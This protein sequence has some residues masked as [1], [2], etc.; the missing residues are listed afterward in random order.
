VGL[1]VCDSADA[2]ATATTTVNV[3]NVA[4]TAVAEADQTVFRGAPVSVSGTWTDPAGA[5]DNAYTWAWDLDGDG[6][7]DVSGQSPFGS[8]NAQTTSF[9][10]LGTYTLTFRVTDKD[11]ASHSD[12][13]TITV[14]NR[15]PDC[16]AAAPS[17]SLIWPPNHQMVGVSVQGVT[18]ADNDPLTLTISSIHQDEPVNAIGDGNTGVDGTGVGSSEAMVR[19]ERSG[20]K[21]NFGNGRVYHIG[22]TADDGQGGSCSGVV[23]V[24]VPHDQ[25]GK[26]QPVDDGPLYDSTK[27]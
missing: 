3:L 11:G 22:Y 8:T 13:V 2:C 16:S 9:A 21:Q 25:G 14:V 19:A 12:T 17:T 23:R 20:T 1:R 27:P 4:P 15:P 10:A 26:A 7:F 18:D 6:T 5:S 24:G